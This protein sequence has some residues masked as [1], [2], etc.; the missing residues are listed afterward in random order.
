MMM[1]A[2]LAALAPCDPVPGA[3]PLLRPGAVLLLGEIH[4]TTE[5]PKAL[6]KLSCLAV[7]KGLAMTVALEIPVSERG[8]VDR[9]MTGGARS[10]LLSGA[11]WLREYQDGRSS[12]A[13]LELLTALRTLRGRAEAAVDVVLIDDPEADGGRDRFMAERLAER[14]GRFSEHL[15]LALVGN[16]HNRLT[17]GTRFDP[18]YEPMG[19]LLTQLRPDAGIDSLRITHGGGTAWVCTGTQ[20]SDCGVRELSGREGVAGIEMFGDVGEAAPFSGRFHVEQVTASPPARD[21]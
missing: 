6:S 17:V 4:G 11:F 12:A 20:A 8:R 7:E 18:A 15:I 1:L 3:E 19:W 16:V 14:I 2:L 10:Q 9:F 13:M 21:K 5:S